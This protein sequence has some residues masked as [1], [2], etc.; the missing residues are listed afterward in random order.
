MEVNASDIDAWKFLAGLMLFLLAM[1][2]IEQAIQALAG[3]TFKTLIASNT[4]TPLRGIL[5]GTVATAVLQSSSLVSLMMLAF[6]GARVIRMKDA[7]LVVFGANLGTTATGWIVA[8]I[9][10]KFDLEDLALPLIALGG[11][12]AVIV[13]RHRVSE[14]GRLVLGIGVLLLALQF[15]KGAVQGVAA[16]IDPQVLIDMSAIEYLLFGALFSAV[17][18]S[19]SATMVITLS[20]LHAGALEL[21]DAAALMIG[22]DLGTTSTVLLGAIG[23]TANKKRLAFG[24][25][26]FNL[27]TDVLAFVLLGPL[28]WLLSP[29]KDPLITLVAFHSSFNL[30]GLLLWTPLIAQFAAFL[31]RWF[32]TADDKV[33]RYLEDTAQAVPE[34]AIRALR[35]EVAH[36]MARVISQ[37]GAAF[38]ITPTRDDVAAEFIDAY[39]TSRNLEGEILSYALDLDRASLSGP[40]N[41][42]LSMLLHVTRDAMVSSKHLKDV[43][44]DFREVAD[45]SEPLYT[46]FRDTQASFYRHLL[47]VSEH[48]GALR[49][50]QLE[51]L[52]AEVEEGHRQCHEQIYAEIRADRLAEPRMSS[53]LNINRSFFNSNRAML[54]SMMELAEHNELTAQSQL[55]LGG[56]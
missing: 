56:G 31:E 49:F 43:L 23:G 21:T 13:Q 44:L 33:S 3:R 18:Q 15:M 16:W 6:V 12:C 26:L 17:V 45:D 55:A 1:G 22:A 27:V 42:S 40:E 29:L 35:Q 54:S 8:T 41:E 4:S 11:L 52:A 34:A 20:L 14:I 28:L 2:L 32:E 25:F 50:N 10:F 47:E 38:G 36:L 24:H 19:S 7:L 30:L 37:N 48:P 39:H 53:I 9:G 5:S 51:A 46:L